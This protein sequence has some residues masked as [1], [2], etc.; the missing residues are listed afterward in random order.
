[1]IKNYI[2]VWSS[3][4]SSPIFRG[5]TTF[6]VNI[7]QV[8]VYQFS[9]EDASSSSMVGVVGGIP[10]GATLTRYQE[11]YRFSWIL[12]S[13]SQNISLIFYA[14]DLKNKLIT[15]QYAVQVQ[16]CNCQNGRVCTSN[17]LVGSNITTAVILNCTCP[18]G[19][20]M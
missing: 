5:D 17:G 1:M 11:T 20:Y 4:I 15:T 13:P 9:V 7:G 6:V 18:R 12:N 19:W 2:S 14:T 10:S 3:E 16:L 8:S